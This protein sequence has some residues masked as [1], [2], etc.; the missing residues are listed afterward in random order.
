MKITKLEVKN[1]RLLKDF[2]MDV[3]EKMSVV[4]G[5]NNC[6]KTSLL[7]I[8]N[9]FLGDNDD[10]FTFD[11]FNIFYRKNI[12]ECF[13][14]N[15]DARKKILNKDEY[16]KIMGG[17]PICISLT[18]TIEYNIDDNLSNIACFFTDLNPQNTEVKIKCKYELSYEKYKNLHNDYKKN[19]KNNKN[20]QNI[21]EYFEKYLSRYME[22][23]YYTIDN[24]NNEYQVNKMFIKKLIR[25]KFISASREVKSNDQNNITI[26]KL[27]QLASKY[28]NNRNDSDE[29]NSDLEASLQKFDGEIDEKYEK[30]FK[31]IIKDFEQFSYKE[32]ESKFKIKSKLDGNSILKNNTTV[33]YGNNK[34]LLPEG[35]NGLGYLNLFSI[36]FQIKIIFDE[37]RKI[38]DTSADSA[39][40]NILF[41]EEPEAHAHPQM[42]YI[43]I[44]N[45]KDKIMEYMDETKKINV[46]SILTS[47]SSHIVSQ[48]EFDCIKYFHHNNDTEGIIVK[49]LSGLEK[50]IKELEDGEARFRFLKQYLTLEKSEMFFADKIIMIEGDTERILINDMMK[51]FDNK[52]MNDEKYKSMIS[53]NI[54][55]VEVGAYGCI[56]KELIEFL[57]IQTLI[58]TDI[59]S[60]DYENKDENINLKETS[61]STNQTKKKPRRLRKCPVCDGVETNN[62]TLKDFYRDLKFEDLRKYNLEKKLKHLH[63]FNNGNLLVTYQ[64]EVNSYQGY[65]FE[66]AF[67][68]ENFNYFKSVYE[69]FTSLKNLKKLKKYIK[70]NDFYKIAD[71]CIDK[72]SGFAF[73]ILFFDSFNNE[74]LSWYIPSYIKEGF[75]WLNCGKIK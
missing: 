68:S 42:Q 38:K 56:F 50:K 27:S 5:K 70:N 49:N 52:N 73:D 11:D 58:I 59:D 26:N 20:N 25:F 53:Q 66:D 14:H 54:S 17:N 46:Q 57:E 51:K 21:H 10:R 18:L 75:E 62:K 40:I 48:C 9:K 23:K 55:V 47:H 61:K 44:K 32:S 7:A 3:N 4:I 28:Y 74:E 36:I 72:K 16:F 13:N 29:D 64:S 35:Y 71:E 60:G 63:K 31:S 43:F 19:K 65:S 30:I 1:F 41:I 69:N 34:D 45:I 37:F 22:V 33:L 39:D 8:L 67:I 6:G 15:N 12:N 24:M 2:S